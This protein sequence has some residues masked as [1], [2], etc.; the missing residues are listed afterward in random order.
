MTEIKEKKPVFETEKDIRFL[1][2]G[3]ELKKYKIVSE[4]LKETSQSRVFKFLLTEKFQYIQSLKL[5][6]PPTKQIVQA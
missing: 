5:E 3:P 2:K 6:N 1:L 4:F